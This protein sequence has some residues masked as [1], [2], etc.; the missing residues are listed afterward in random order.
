[1]SRQPLNLPVG[2]VIRLRDFDASY[3]D[4]Q[5]D[6]KSAKLRIRE[7]TKQLDELGHR[8]YAE[9]R[10]ALLLVLQGM[11]TAGK[12]GTIRT[13]LR[14]INPQIC[15]IA[16]FKAPS[17]VELDH[18][19]LW[20]VHNATPRHGEVGIF[21]RSHYEDVLIVRV[22]ELAP[23][24]EWR[25]RYERINEFERLLTQGGITIVK[26]FL[27]VSKEEQ[28][29]R[30]QSRLDRPEK[31]WKF[32]PGDLETRARWD[33][34]QAAYED[35]LNR[36]N[37]AHAPWHIIPSDRKWYRNLAVSQL[38]LDTMVRMAPQF[39][40]AEGNFENVVIE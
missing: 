36:C 7:N 10:Q 24:S 34:Y 23:E 6:K 37:T 30:L 20:R 31:R 35:A 25:S 38:V 29:E 11:D 32:N 16:S 4:P 33:D 2:Q 19:F 18:D 1:M 5:F 3:H 8:L 21:N 12:D 40:A 9:N 15:R 39:P 13:V 22:E 26:C 17:H 14:G 27:H 28:R